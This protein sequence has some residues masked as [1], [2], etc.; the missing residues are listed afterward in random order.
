[1]DLQ[2][3]FVSLVIFVWQNC[4]IAS[5]EVLVLISLVD[6]QSHFVSLVIFVWQNCTIASLEV[7][8]VRLVELD[9]HQTA[10]SNYPI[11]KLTHQLLITNHYLLIK[12]L[13]LQSVSATYLKV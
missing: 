13:R 6:L 3:H 10:T 4:R 2:F 8:G 9:L 11:K 5:R 1:V 7:K 12:A